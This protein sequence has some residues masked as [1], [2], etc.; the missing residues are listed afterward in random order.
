MHV[1]VMLA[2]LL[3][4]CLICSLFLSWP[5]N[6]L[7]KTSIETGSTKIRL[8]WVKFGHSEKN[9]KSEKNLPL[10]IWHYWVK[11]NFK[12]KIFSDFV[13]FSE[14]PN[15]TETVWHF[16]RNK[17][18]FN[19]YWHHPFTQRVWICFNEFSSQYFFVLK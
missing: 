8:P 1:E 7:C 10:K 4:F 18:H 19:F 9:T 3:N 17:T 5:A 6:F 2:K 13:S 14:C 12:W 15:F 16:L 11:S